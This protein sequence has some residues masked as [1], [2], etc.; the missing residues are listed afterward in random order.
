MMRRP[1]WLERLH[2]F[3]Q[4]RSAVPHKFGENDCCLF[5][6]DAV[7]VMTG[8][9][10]LAHMRGKWSNER[11]ALRILKQLGGL[12]N[13]TTDLLGVPIDPKL[14]QRGDVVYAVGAADSLITVHMGEYL[15]AP[16]KQGMAYI[17]L[18]SAHCAW[19]IGR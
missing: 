14:A 4:S 19:P 10:Y 5:C 17:H 18:D 13:A 11:E 1:D 16:S 12:L 15:L 2:D 3:V 6:A 7:L 9:D 8:H